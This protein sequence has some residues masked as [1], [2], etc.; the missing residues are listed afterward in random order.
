[1]RF[2]Q[3][4]RGTA[5]I[6]RLLDRCRLMTD[7]IAVLDLSA[8]SGMIMGVLSAIRMQKWFMKLSGRAVDNS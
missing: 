5:Q 6:N 1:M 3:N 8:P 4:N 7:L 2:K